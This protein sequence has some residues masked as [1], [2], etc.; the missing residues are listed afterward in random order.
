MLFHD[1]GREALRA[2]RLSVA[3]ALITTLIGCARREDFQGAPIDS[4]PN[5]PS[6][7]PAIQPPTGKGCSDVSDLASMRIKNAAAAIAGNRDLTTF[8]SALRR[9]DL[10][11]SLNASSS[12]TIFVPTNEAFEK[13]LP[14]KRAAWSNSASLRSILRSHIVSGRVPPDELLGAH[15]TVGGG[16]ILVAENR[17]DM[18]VNGIAR[19]TCSD[20]VTTNAVIYFLDSVLEAT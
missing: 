9:V 1:S 20:I 19:I 5:V 8:A 2:F 3:V 17:G 16:N 11:T 12:L 18:I 7:S 6:A 13:W 10:M 15:P 4:A 14:G